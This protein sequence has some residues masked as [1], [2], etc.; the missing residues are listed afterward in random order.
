MFNI[1]NKEDFYRLAALNFAGTAAMNRYTAVVHV[2]GKTDIIFWNKIFYKYYPRGKFHFIYYSKTFKNDEDSTI[3]SGSTQCLNYKPYLSEKFFIC[4]DSDYRYLQQEE[5]IN[6]KNYIFQTY[7]YSIE[8]HYCYAPIL[9][10]QLEKASFLKNN[11][12]DFDI[13]L[14][15]YS[16]LIYEF[17]IWQQVLLNEDTGIYSVRVIPFNNIITVKGKIPYWQLKNN[18]KELLNR[19]K[20]KIDKELNKIKVEYNHIDITKEMEHYKQL[21]V[22]KDNTYL[23]I[24]GHHLMNFV[25][26]I[27]E[28]CIEILF[29]KRKKN[30]NS[31]EIK[32]IKKRMSSFKS[33]IDNNITFDDYFCLNK[34]K[35]DVD[36]MFNKKK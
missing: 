36:F 16:N 22:T 23:F 17:F 34:I 24:R 2:E 21:G 25:C 30:K 7:T 28:R 6:I 14:K 11:F 4:I 32:K 1:D 15:N 10:K 9:N 27:G 19:I 35:E 13:F 3:A 33:V 5:G 8:N 18:G 29:A 26:K 20:Q 12:F 31:K